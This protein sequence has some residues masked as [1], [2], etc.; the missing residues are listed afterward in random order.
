MPIPKKY[1]FKT[2]EPYG[3]LS[4][5]LRESLSDTIDRITDNNRKKEEAKQ[6]AAEKEAFM[7][8]TKKRSTPENV[9]KTVFTTLLGDPTRTYEITDK[10][11]N[12]N[13]EEVGR[14]AQ[15]PAY[16]TALQN[17]IHKKA[18][19]DFVEPHVS[20]IVT[21][22][23]RDFSNN[24]SGFLG[25]IGGSIYA[26]GNLPKGLLEPLSS[27]Q[28]P[29]ASWGGVPQ[30]TYMQIVGGRPAQKKEFIKAGYIEGRP[31]DYGLVQTATHALN[32]RRNDSIPVYQTMPDTI[33]R[34]NL[35][36]LGNIH[37]NSHNY[38]GESWFAQPEAT[39]W[40][41]AEYPTA[42][43]IDPRTGV[44]YQN[45]WDLNDYGVAN[46]GTAKLYNKQVQKVANWVDRHGLPTVVTTGY[47]P[48]ITWDEFTEALTTENPTTVWE[49][50]INRPLH[51]GRYES[52]YQ[53]LSP[54]IHD[55]T[56]MINYIKHY[57]YDNYIKDHNPD[58]P[59]KRQRFDDYTRYLQNNNNP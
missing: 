16:R 19:V 23:G 18:Y 48:F 21:Q 22:A 40:H 29:K 35:V 2:E 7:G 24:S 1:Q 49:K 42:A 46:G 30:R 17:Q 56:D 8:N 57:G 26:E 12:F 11:G 25:N 47:Q 58:D 44:I 38:V 43:Y 20:A 36:L 41:A 13:F 59:I 51:R 37:N 45:A 5:G 14:A 15:N 27:W 53:Q 3:W 52:I 4:P 34:E 10:N 9:L 32:E 33:S 31:G 39:L 6:R 50:Y 54:L 55:Y 28:N